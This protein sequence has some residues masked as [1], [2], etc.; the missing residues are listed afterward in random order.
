MT[1]GKGRAGQIRSNVTTASVQ[2]AALDLV[3]EL[4]PSRVTIDGIPTTSGVVKT[5]IYSRW[6]NAAAVIMDAFLAGISAPYRLSTGINATRNL[7]ERSSRLRA[8]SIR[9][10]ATFCTT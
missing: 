4:G 8:R 5:T 2:A 10:V 1:T 3:R 6:P 7:P 9:H